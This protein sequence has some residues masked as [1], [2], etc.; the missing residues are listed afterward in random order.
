LPHIKAETMNA[1]EAPRRNREVL[2]MS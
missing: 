2:I 1:A